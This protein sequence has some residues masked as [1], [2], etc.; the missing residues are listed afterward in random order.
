RR[1]TSTIAQPTNSAHTSAKRVWTPRSGRAVSHG[2]WSTRLVEASVPRSFERWPARSVSRAT[3]SV[4]AEVNDAAGV[5]SLHPQAASR[6]RLDPGQRAALGEFQPQ[7]FVAQLPLAALGL[8]ALDVV[9]G[10]RYAARFE[11]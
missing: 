1:H 11:Q 3:R 8:Q 7:L 10:G 2:R 9:T 5:R 4:S 6:L